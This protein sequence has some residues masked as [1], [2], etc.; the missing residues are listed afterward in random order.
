MTKLPRRAAI[1]LALGTLA[2]PRLARA[3]WPER[4]ITIIVPLAAGGGTDITARNVAAFLSRDLGQ[5]VVVQNRPGAGGALGY[6]A[7]AEA[8]PD[9]YTL[10]I[11][12][13]PGAVIIPIERTSRFSLASF[14][15]LAGVIE[16]PAVIAVRPDSGIR[17]AAELVERARR[18]PRSVTASIQGVGGSAWVSMRILEQAAGAQFELVIY[19]SAPAAVL[20]MVQRDVVVGTAN[21]GEGMMMTAGQPWQVLGVMAKDRNPLAPE[22]PTLREQGIDAIAT[23]VRGFSGPRGLPAEVVARLSAAFDRMAADAEFQAT[24]RRTFQ[25]LN[26]MDAPAF[27]AHLRAED[28]FF[29]AMW[30]RQPWTN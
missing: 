13:T 27:A 15:P 3:A 18:A 1:G 9:G 29:R 10:G 23:T 6:T 22:V 19:N 20:A 28:E 21:L 30:A 26:Y 25:P 7:L 4:P 11:T 24:C 14:T 2:T 5:P 17:S 12:N 8:A 16:D